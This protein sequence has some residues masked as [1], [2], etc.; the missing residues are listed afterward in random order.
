MRRRQY[1]VSG[2]LILI[3][4][5]DVHMGLD[6]LLTPVHM[7][8]PEYGPL[9]PPCGRHK[10]MAQLDSIVILSVLKRANPEIDLLCLTFSIRKRLAFFL[11]YFFV[12]R[13]LTFISCRK[14]CSLLKIKVGLIV[15]CSCEVIKDQKTKESLQYAFIEFEKVGKSWILNFKLLAYS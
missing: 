2:L 14:F 1:D 15:F 6:P 4:C 8:P 5:V 7:H 3:F 9:P 12:Y 13:R 10:W 11:E